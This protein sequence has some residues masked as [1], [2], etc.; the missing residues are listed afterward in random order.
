MLDGLEDAPGGEESAPQNGPGDAPGIAGSSARTGSGPALLFEPGGSGD[1]PGGAPS[2]ALRAPAAPPEPGGRPAPDLER[3]LLDGL[4]DAPGPEG[5][6]PEVSPNDPLDGA[7]ALSGALSEPSPAVEPSS[8]ADPERLEE[9]L[10][11]AFIAALPDPDPPPDG[12]P[13]AGPD[14]ERRLL[15]GLEDAPGSATSTPEDG[16]PVAFDP[17]G[18]PAQSDSPPPPFGP[19]D[20]EAPPDPALAPTPADADPPHEPAPRLDASRLAGPDDPAGRPPPGLPPPPGAELERTLVEGLTDIPE[21][22]RY[23]QG[24]A[25]DSLGPGPG[26]A[27]PPEAAHFEPPAGPSPTSLADWSSPR[28]PDLEEALLEGL[29]DATD[30]AGSPEADERPDPA[31]GPLEDA[32]EVHPASDF[33]DPPGAAAAT[34]AAE[35]EAAPLPREDGFPA[36]GSE[37]AALAFATDPDT[38]SALR[39]GL[40]DLA[41]PQVWP[42]GLGTAIDVLG[43]GHASRMIFVDLDETPYPAGAMHELAAVCE[44]GTVVVALGSDATARFSRELLL[45][46]VS[47]YLVKP[48]TAAAVREAATRAASPAPGEAAGGWSV[49][50]AGTGGSGATT[51]A[52]ALALV[53]ADRGRYVSVLDLDRTFPALSFLLDVEPSA[54]LVEILSTAARA[55]LH[56][57]MVDGLRAERTE[58]IAVYGYPWSVTPPPLAPVWAVCELLVEL[59]RRSHLVLVDGIDDPATRLALLALVDARVLVVEPTPHGAAHAAQVLDRFGPMFDEEWPFL[60]VQN[61]TRAFSPKAGAAALDAAGVDTPADVVIPFEPSLPAVADRGWPRGRIPRSIQAS[62]GVLA[63]RVLAGEKAAGVPAPA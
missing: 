39:E 7:G 52:A 21:P 45:A 16:S 55:S 60:L 12:G 54:G 61:H 5:F 6:T 2:P 50:F 59:Q 8:L 29:D 40:A 46:G 18:I 25:A 53:A 23:S 19:D 62:V 30:S 20:P 26:A 38:E 49:G 3:R 63:D 28:A 9:P 14:L 41:D 37:P 42:G 47:D 43:A 44:V 58:R 51:V 1:A 11:P 24:L 27:P 4:E 48:V 56:P 57:E 35:P 13:A 31:S 15:D 10:D 17:A 34:L 22:D 33:S 32:F 36:A